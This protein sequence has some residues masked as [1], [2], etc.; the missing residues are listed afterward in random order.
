MSD[1]TD[2]VYKSMGSDLKFLFKPLFTHFA[3]CLFKP[4]LNLLSSVYANFHHLASLNPLPKCIVN[5]FNLE[6]GIERV[7]ERRLNRIVLLYVCSCV[8]K[9]LLIKI[10]TSTEYLPG[11]CGQKHNVTFPVFWSSVF[12]LET[13]SRR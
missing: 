10:F 12:N 5:Y 6:N 9:A 3:K 4:I 11:T 13:S 7:Q 1:T 2:E 8:S